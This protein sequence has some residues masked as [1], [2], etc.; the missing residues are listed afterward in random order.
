M[1]GN[2][3][4]ENTTDKV[5]TRQIRELST[6]V[7]GPRVNMMVLELLHGLMAASIKVNGVIV[8]KM[9]KESLLASMDLYTKA[10]GSMENI[11]VEENYKHQRVKYS[12]E[13]LRTGNF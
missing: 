13:R 1:K 9:D 6:M 5:F 3:V 2:G 4:G 12:P 11:M 8:E 7:I 10:I